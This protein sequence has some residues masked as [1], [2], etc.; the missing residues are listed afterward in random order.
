MERVYNYRALILDMI[1]S[2]QPTYS[3]LATTGV[4]ENAKKRAYAEFQALKIFH[5][6]FPTQH[7]NKSRIRFHNQP[8]V[9]LLEKS[10][11]KKI[12]LLDFFI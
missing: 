9:R 10:P 8:N 5:C 1:N 2:S 6:Q 3:K 7:P 12:Y 4:S 11:I